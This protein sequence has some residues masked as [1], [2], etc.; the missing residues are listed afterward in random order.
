MKLNWNHRLGASDNGPGATSDEDFGCRAWDVHKEGTQ[1]TK[2]GSGS[3]PRVVFQKKF[4]CP[5]SHDML[6]TRACQ[7]P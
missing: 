2:H 6:S 4:K 3:K 1:G 7:I 5:I